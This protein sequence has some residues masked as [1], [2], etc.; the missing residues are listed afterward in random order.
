M[1]KVFSSQLDLTDLPTGH[2]DVEYF[3]YGS[4]FVWDSTCLARYVV[5]TLDSIIE[6]HLLLVGTSAKRLN[7]S[8]SRRTLAHCRYI[9]KHLH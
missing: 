3:T 4:S 6:A 8:P 2:V 1:D 9:G 5:V 7:S